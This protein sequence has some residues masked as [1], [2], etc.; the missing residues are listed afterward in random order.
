MFY[1]ETP[2]EGFDLQLL[3]PGFVF[4]LPL[5]KK[6]KMPTVKAR[7]TNGITN[8]INPDWMILSLKRHHEL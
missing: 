2:P 1:F 8:N 6:I 3:V 5:K 4:F 7:R